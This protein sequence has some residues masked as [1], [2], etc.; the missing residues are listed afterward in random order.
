[1]RKI[2][3][4]SNPQL[5]RCIDPY[6]FEGFI[7]DQTR[8]SNLL[9]P[10][11]VNYGL[12]DRIYNDNR[13]LWNDILNEGIRANIALSLKNFQLFE[14]FPRSPGLYYLPE[15]EWARKE[16]MYY[17]TTSSSEGDLW[18]I[19]EANRISS[20]NSA[21]LPST[22]DNSMLIFT[23]QGKSRMLLGGIG[24]IR[25]RDQEIPEGKVWFMSA[26][27]TPVAHEGFP[28]ALPDFFYQKYIDQIINEGAISCTVTGHLRFLPDQ[29]NTLFRDYPNV[30]QLYLL[31]MSCTLILMTLAKNR[32]V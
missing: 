1:M 21:Y 19:D 30:P 7:N 8:L 22:K 9:R 20:K 10:S 4:I 13:S 24:C 27:S 28:L 11:E 18:E 3:N 25:L 6:Y 31:L 26:S 32:T 14:W 15:A 23:P 2:E 16:A 29:L 12:P 5:F 17:L